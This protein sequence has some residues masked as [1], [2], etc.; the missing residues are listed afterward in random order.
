ML[1]LLY[2]YSLC[3]PKP[4]GLELSIVH[5]ACAVEEVFIVHP[6]SVLCFQF[7]PHVPQCVPGE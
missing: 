5:I 2:I 7:Q 3:L 6:I 1:T 4:D